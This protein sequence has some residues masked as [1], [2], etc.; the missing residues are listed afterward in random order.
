MTARGTVEVNGAVS[1]PEASVF[2]GDRIATGE[3]AAVALVLPGGNQVFLPEHTQAIVEQSGA[4]VLV[5]LES[6]A[7]AVTGRSKSPIGIVARGLEIE[8]SATSAVFEV[9]LKE[10]GL[11]VMARRGSAI[12]RG[13]NK[14]VEVKEGMTLDATAGAAAQGPQGV[15]AAGLS[16]LTTAVVVASVTLG[17]AGFAMGLAAL[18]RSDPQDCQ[19]SGSASPF[20]ITCP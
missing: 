5:R 11:R 13:S 18:S 19:V 8:A 20:T 14:S 6:G 12:V 10:G 2:S 9:A 4:R 7:L 16:P 3:N 1:S 15:G 17:I